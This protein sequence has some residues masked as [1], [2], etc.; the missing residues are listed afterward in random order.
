MENHERPVKKTSVA[1]TFKT[2]AMVDVMTYFDSSER[3]SAAPESAIS[4]SDA[5]MAAGDADGSALAEAL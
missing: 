5:V 4:C 2:S 3:T 1:E